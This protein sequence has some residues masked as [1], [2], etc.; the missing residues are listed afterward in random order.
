MPV[1]KNSNSKII[2][3]YINCAAK[4]PLDHLILTKE[5]A[6]VCH[7]KKNLKNRKEDLTF[8]IPHW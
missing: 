8:S 2:F 4:Y 3:S 7:L 5:S 1:Y 6:E